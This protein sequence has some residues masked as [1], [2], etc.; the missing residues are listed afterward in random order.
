MWNSPKSNRVECRVG[1]DIVMEELE[2]DDEDNWYDYGI[3]QAQKDAITKRLKSK[4]QTV[5]AEDTQ[6]WEPGEWDFF[7][8]QCL[9]LGLNSDFCIED[10]AEDTSGS[11]QFFTGLMRDPV[12]VKSSHLFGWWWIISMAAVDF[13]LAP[14]SLRCPRLYY[15]YLISSHYCFCYV[16]ALGSCPLGPCLQLVSA[17]GPVMCWFFMLKALFHWVGFSLYLL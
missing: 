17:I 3:T 14:G 9:E 13:V 4:S 8:D 11:A 2:E 10:V 5:L 6:N 12:V 15:R 1:A 7:H 16:S